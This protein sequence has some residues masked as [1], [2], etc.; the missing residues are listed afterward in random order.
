M[1]G[2]NGAPG[3]IAPKPAELDLKKGLVLLLNTLASNVMEKHYKVSN[4]TIFHVHLIVNG[5]NGATGALA[6]KL[7]E[8]DL[9]KGTV[10]YHNML[11]MGDN[12]V[13]D[14]LMKQSSAQM[15]HVQFIVNGA[16]GATGVLAPKLVE[17]DLK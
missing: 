7:V 9:K 1:N 14:N 13:V 15:N 2:A 17:L 11:R 4:V 12:S 16:N 5:A 8:M 3:V 6:P 10:K